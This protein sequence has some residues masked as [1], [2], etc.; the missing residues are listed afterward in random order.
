MAG[1]TVLPIQECPDLVAHTIVIPIPDSVWDDGAASAEGAFLFYAE[2]DTVVDAAHFICNV[3]DASGDVT[4]NT[5]AT[6]V[7][8]AGTAIS[9]VLTPGT[10]GTPQAFT[11]TETANLIPAGNWIGVEHDGDADTADITGAMVQLRLRTIIR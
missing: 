3:T 10:A 8:S 6:G 5:A 2:R 11:L 4:L 9:S 1:E 7:A